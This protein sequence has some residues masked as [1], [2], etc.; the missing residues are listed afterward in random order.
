MEVIMAGAHAA[1]VVR[2]TTVRGGSGN[3]DHHWG[4]ARQLSASAAD[5]YRAAGSPLGQLQAL[6]VQ[7]AA[8]GLLG[9]AAAAAE[10]LQHGLG[11]AEAV[12]GRVTQLSVAAGRGHVRLATQEELA[13][14]REVEHQ[15]GLS[16]LAESVRAAPSGRGGSGGGAA[17][18]CPHHHPGLPS[19]A[20]LWSGAARVHGSDARLQ[21]SVRRQAAAQRGLGG[22]AAVA[23]AAAD[24]TAVQQAAAF[25]L[26]KLA[27]STAAA[28]LS[29]QSGSIAGSQGAAAAAAAAAPPGLKV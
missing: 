11:A 2:A 14:L 4:L 1:N 15:F 29:R 23:V 16:G 22:A 10:D 8:R 24:A 18:T 7:L 21:V 12:F 20:T 13:A 19:L 28:F 25:Y 17:V 26:Y 3:E 6:A 27:S 5:A 9:S